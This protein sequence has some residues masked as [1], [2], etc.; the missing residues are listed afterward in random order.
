[1][2]EKSTYIDDIAFPP[3]GW[4][5]SKSSDHELYKLRVIVGDDTVN[6]LIRREVSAPNDV[7][8]SMRDIASY[9]LEL[10]RALALGL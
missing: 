8:Y 9:N 2:N 6:R 4:N 1:M 10:Y 7:Q 5:R 3:V